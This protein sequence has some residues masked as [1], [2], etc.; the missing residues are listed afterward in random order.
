MLFGRQLHTLKIT[1]ALFLRTNERE[2]LT[3]FLPA[4]YTFHEFRG[5]RVFVGYLH[6]STQRM[7]E[8]LLFQ[9]GD[10]NRGRR[11][12]EIRTGDAKRRDT[13]LCIPAEGQPK[14]QLCSVTALP[15]ASSRAALVNIIRRIARIACPARVVR[16]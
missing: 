16:R 15:S 1:V 3:R 6:V 9:L 11:F 2:T 5:P 14:Q 12:L 10:R 8:N 7:H 4:E 13:V